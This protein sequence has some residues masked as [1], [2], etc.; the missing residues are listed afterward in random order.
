MA[1]DM[2]AIQII[3]SRNRILTLLQQAG[4]AMRVSTLLNFMRSFDEHY[5]EGVLKKDLGYLKDPTKGYVEFL[6]D[7]IGG[8]PAFLKK[9]VRITAAGDEIA[10]N[11]QDD[12]ALE[13]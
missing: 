11:L 9:Y 5:H 13:V 6:D 8:F 12:P 4:T 1:K 3:E 2:R 10:N 7:E